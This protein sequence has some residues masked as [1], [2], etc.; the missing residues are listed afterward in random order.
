MSSSPRFRRGTSVIA[1]LVFAAILGAVALGLHAINSN[2]TNTA[3]LPAQAAAATQA[4]STTQ[5]QVQ[6]QAG[7]VY[8]VAIKTGQTYDIQEANIKVNAEG[9]APFTPTF[10]YANS[11][12]AQNQA[13][14]IGDATANACNYKM[15]AGLAVGG[16]DDVCTKVASGGTG[17]SKCISL[18]NVEYS[19]SES[20]TTVSCPTASGGKGNGVEIYSK[21]GAVQVEQC[22]PGSSLQTPSSAT[23]ATSAANTNSATPIVSPNTTGAANPGAAGAFCVTSSNQSGT[24]DN[25]GNCVATTAGNSCTNG[26]TYPD[27]TQCPT[28][29]TMQN[30]IC[31]PSS[32]TETQ[33]CKNGGTPPSCTPP[34]QVPPPTGQLQQPAAQTSNPLGGAGGANLLGSFLSGLMRGIAPCTAQSPAIG[35]NGTTYVQQQVM[36][37]NGLVTTVLVPQ[38]TNGFGTT[39]PCG[40]QN[41]P[42][43]VGTNGAACTQPPAQPTCAAGATAQPIY[44]QGNGC[45]TSYQCVNINGSTFGSTPTPQI[46]CSPQVADVGQ[47]VAISYSCQNATDSSGGGF[48]TNDQL[49]GSAS[50]TITTP[51]SGAN[52]ANYGITCDNSGQ[53]ASAQCSVQVNQ[54]AIDLVANPQS[55]SNGGKA[56]I[57]WVTAG[58]QSCVISSPD[59]ANFT[60]ANASNQS[61][62]GVAQTDAITASTE[63][64]LTCQTL[65]GQTKTAKTIITVGSG[66]SASATSTAS[67]SVNSSVDGATANH[68]GSVTVTWQSS[69]APSGSALALW[70]IDVNTEEATALITGDQQVNG[71]YQW[72]IPA[73]GSSCNSNS[74]DACASDLVAGDSY[75]IEAAVYTPSDANLGDGSEPSSNPSPSYSGYGYTAT[76]FTIGQ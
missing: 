70:L 23:P 58:M 40:Q 46:S 32:Y 64:D 27:C 65:G 62:S 2:S 13:I 75:G 39:Q 30:G 63:F 61:V 52:T 1:A 38:T 69:N 44:G 36:Q 5:D 10:T 56:T 66:S 59:D 35:G 71:T 49:S 50:S 34:A 14:Q 11:N 54:P 72:Q 68:G 55:V 21:D 25:S 24:V 76:P 47:S 9:S 67:V 15:E 41:A 8:Y 26:A 12:F 60:S 18:Y 42:Y 7:H 51:P 16:T 31:N 57:G 28:G 45:V 6:C 37:P 4:A 74:D 48:S 43:G 33:T 17:D 3:A 22:T 19:G 29:M 73:V 53:T 20:H